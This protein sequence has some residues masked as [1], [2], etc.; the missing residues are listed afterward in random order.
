MAKR[1][2][3]SATSWV[4]LGVVTF[5]LFLEVGLVKSFSVL[6]PDIKEQFDTYTWVLG[7]SVSIIIGWGS[8]AGKVVEV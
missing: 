1:T 3:D 4:V 5:S 8:I 6:L 7:S 2:R